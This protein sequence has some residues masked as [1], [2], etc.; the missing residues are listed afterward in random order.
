MTIT[1]EDGAAEIFVLDGNLQL[2]GRGI[3]RVRADLPQGIYKI[4]RRVAAEAQEDLL[5]HAAPGTDKRYP[6]LAFSSPV[7]LALTVE[8]SA[9]HAEAARRESRT[10]HVT[11]GTGSS[12]FVFARDREGGGPTAPPGVHPAAGLRLQTSDGGPVADVETRSSR[13][14]DASGGW[15]ACTTSLNP[16]IYRLSV[17][18]AEGQVFA[19][20]IAAAPGWQTQIFLMRRKDEARANQGSSAILVVREGGFDPGSQDLRLIEIARQG[21]LN[22]RPVLSDE[23]RAMLRSRLEQPWLGILAGHLLLQEER[24]DLAVVKTVVGKVRDLLGAP[25][26]DAEALALMAGLDTDFQ[27]SLPP[28]LR[29]SWQGVVAATGR[30]RDLVPAGSLAAGLYSKLTNQEPWLIW[31]EGEAD[32]HD[33]IDVFHDV[34]SQLMKQDPLK[35]LRARI[36]RDLAGDRGN[37]LAGLGRSVGSMIGAARQS[38]GGI[39]DAVMEKLVARLGIPRSAIESMIH[40]AVRRLR[41]L[42]EG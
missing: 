24:P 25:H 28:M 37:I 30:R 36:E 9:G 12:I 19:Q 22:R 13:G 6:P 20:S 26:P 3:G 34:L 16:G 32:D 38:R 1:T 31:R 10:V 4:K 23:T 18:M 14:T 40:D 11:A 8:H 21:L 33:V 27:F 41:K 17:T 15:A 42:G 39:S 35:D 29:R 5:V 7:P 2:V